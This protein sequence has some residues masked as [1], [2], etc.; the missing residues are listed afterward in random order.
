MQLFVRQAQ[1]IRLDFQPGAAEMPAVVEICRLAEGLPLVLEL[2]AAMM[3]DLD[4][5]GIVDRLVAE[6][7]VV[8]AGYYDLPLRQ[9]SL[10]ATLNY[11]WDLLT[12]AEQQTFSRVAIFRGA[13]D[14][15]AAA[16]VTGARA[17]QVQALVDKSLL[18]ENRRGSRLTDPARELPAGAQPLYTLHPLARQFAWRKMSGRLAV[19]ERHAAYFL[20]L[21][22]EEGAGLAGD[23]AAAAA[24][25]LGRAQNDIRQA[26][27]WAVEHNR[28]DL[29][30][31]AVEAWSAYLAL[32]G[33][34]KEAEVIFGAAVERL[35]DRPEM[36]A[37][38][39]LAQAGARQKLGDYQGGLVLVD[40]AQA[41]L[42]EAATELARP[43]G[44]I[45]AAQACVRR[46]HL[47]ELTGNYEAALDQLQAAL[48]L[49]PS[50]YT[51]SE[52]AAALDRMGSI[53]WRS[54]Q[55]QRALAVLQEA[56]DLEIAAGRRG[57]LA[58]YLGNL[59]LVTKDMGAYEQA[60]DYLQQA[61]ATAEAQGHREDTARF[62][63]N[64]GL[65]YWQTGRVDE[66][67]E[68]YQRA[69]SLA[70]ALNHKRGIATC[71]GNMGV[72]ARL[73]GRYA[74]ALGYYQEGLALARDLGE[75]ALEAMLLGNTGNVYMDMGQFKPA[76]DTLQQAV[77]MD[78]ELGNLDGVARHL[79][80]LGD[81]HKYAGK[82]VDAAG[83]FGEALHL[84]RRSGNKYYLCWVLVAGAEVGLERALG[85]ADRVNLLAEVAAMNDEGGKLA[86]E[87]G[88]REYAF[89]SR[90]L[91]GRVRAAQG[92]RP[93]AIAHLETLP[94][95]AENAEEAAAV[96]FALW[97]VKGTEK[98]RIVAHEQYQALAA[99]MPKA[100]YRTRLSAL[101]R[102]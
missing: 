98:T 9:R 3:A 4:P 55:Y 12:E 64:V 79:G 24:T 67:Q 86:T 10:S 85:A 35:D 13:F 78:R 95:E 92:D 54:S 57:R 5:A 84:L 38:L 18:Q 47:L 59:G 1:R 61:L 70:R 49:L 52:R 31:P 80:N 19:E 41:M 39:L 58:R 23:E 65:V 34:Y 88:R 56:M 11:A 40:Q 16:A 14:Q 68:Y 48:D 100:L 26:W 66:A 81:L 53:Y 42:A 50:G 77:A 63:L 17:D 91:A 97:Q 32:S 51:G 93:G 90:V 69:L 25:R 99:E 60:L 82:N 37:R 102:K 72:L 21:V 30:A 62:S 33:L 96:A 15:Q 89:A 36:A 46:G 45:V 2:A 87:I 29:F 74:E 6:P 75:K 44:E 27:Q 7:D 73:G 71:L 43:G 83:Y 22:A 94:D 76:V 101:D 28:P 8:E 20:N